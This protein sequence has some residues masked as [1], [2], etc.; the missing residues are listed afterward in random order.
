MPTQ[1][2][3]VVLTWNNLD[4]LK[5]FLPILIDRTPSDKAAIIIADNGSEDGTVAWLTTEF[6]DIEVI[7]FNTNY[8]FTGGYERAMQQVTTPFSVL[9]NSD[10]EVLPGWLDPLLETM[11]DRRVAAVMPKINSHSVPSSFEYAGAAGGW[12]DQYGYPFCRGRVFSTIEED[13][14]QY[15]DQVSVFWASGACMMVRMETYRKAGGLDTAFFAHM[16][17]IDLCWRFKRLGYEVWCNPASTVLH[18]GGGTLP[19]EHPHKIYLNFRNS[20][21]LLYKNLPLRNRRKILF[22]R[23]ILDGIAAIQFMISGKF[24]FVSS[25]LK[26]HRHYHK[27]LRQYQKSDTWPQAQASDTVIQSGL[28]KGSIVWDY[29]VRGRKKFTDLKF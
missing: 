3:I 17:E 1:V 6:P 2:S 15:D 12:I 9:L 24:S 27:M 21:L 28:Y 23:K 10:I 22:I 4:Y 14:G 16:E 5:Q 19:N 29:F 7:S 13:S 26:A 25:V 18:V 8:G 11:T 20:L